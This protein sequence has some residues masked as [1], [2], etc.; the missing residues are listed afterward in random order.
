MLGYTVYA[1]AVVPLVEPSVKLSSS[2]SDFVVDSRDDVYSGLFPP[3]S[4]EQEHPKILETEHGTLLFD[5]YRPGE[6]RRQLHLNRCSFVRFLTSG[7]TSDPAI[8]REER[9]IILR[10]P[11]GATLVFDKPMDLAR[12]EF[13]NLVGGQLEGEIEIY[14]PPSK[15]GADDA[16][17]I[18]T[19]DIQIDADEIWTEADVEFRYGPNRG[20]GR[21]LH[22]RWEGAP[23][24]SSASGSRGIHSME[25]VHL[26][27]LTLEIPDDAEG[28]VA[29]QRNKADSDGASPTVPIA[30]AR[31]DRT[32]VDVSCQ[33]P[34]RWDMRSNALTLH[35][36]VRILRHATQGAS[37]QLNCELL[38][39]HFTGGVED[40]PQVTASASKTRETNMRLKKILA[41][42]FPVI[43]RL[44]SRDLTVRAERMEYDFLERRFFLEDTN[45]FQVEDARY[46][47][48]ARRMEYWLGDQGRLGS[49]SAK[50]PGHL[51]G[52]GDE[53]TPPFEV[54][55][56]DEIVLRP[57]EEQPV[58]SLLGSAWLQWD[59]TSQFASD[60]LHVF[61]NESL[62]RRTKKWVVQ[63]DRMKALGH[64]QVDSPQ[65]V[66]NLNEANI[67]FRHVP[68]ATGEGETRA[69]ESSPHRP[70]AGN[71]R[72][73]RSASRPKDV[74]QYELTA[75]LLRAQVVLEDSL[76]VDRL[77]LTGG[78]TFRERSAPG[79]AAM[80]M[81]G[82]TF[83]L[84]GGTT[85]A[86]QAV[87]VGRP[88]S[89][90]ARGM[91]L[92]GPEIIV[93]QGSNTMEIDGSGMMTISPS[94]RDVN[95][96][97]MAPTHIEW[98]DGMT[99]DGSLA[100][101]VGNVTVRGD[102]PAEDGSWTRL[103]VLAESL[104]ATLTRRVDFSRPRVDGKT[105]L[106]RLACRQEVFL[107]TQWFDRGGERRAWQQMQSQNLMVDQVS[108][109]LRGDGPGWLTSVH[110][111][112]SW[113][114]G[115]DRLPP[116]GHWQSPLEYLR[117]DFARE[118]RGQLNHG[119]I[120][121]LGKVRTIYGP[122]DGWNERI[123]LA[124][125]TQLPPR[126]VLLNCDR[127]AVADMSPRVGALQSIELE[128]TGNAIV[129]GETFSA[130]GQRI[131]YN[132]AK[133]Q[134][135]LEGDGRTDAV[136]KYAPQPGAAPAELTGRKIL[137]WPDTRQFELNDV[138]S[139]DIRD[140]PSLR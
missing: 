86:A 134:L 100:R 75:D 5:D 32:P 106:G 6:D 67:W 98:R 84:D 47:V 81:T 52:L 118:L 25:L 38:E 123:E 119:Q 117:V 97:P 62:D 82:D 65:L 17:R 4:W 73:Q 64:V 24:T 126:V 79:S 80:V 107:E 7:S 78:V 136:L 95:K 35:D 104:E 60:E 19:R 124:R 55:W 54:T 48:E 130:A 101:F 57:Y 72:S 27:E 121:F 20:R 22:I 111:R 53:S 13:G 109:S 63:P 133:D 31:R 49:L 125:T 16:I 99:F 56:S 92:K 131:S 96:P 105:E 116:A 132:R 85:D 44:P 102:R 8:Q 71:E 83:Q 94:A 42:G 139:L 37:D 66:A 51:W 128:A 50:G 89:V 113:S 29:G 70:V 140:L 46:R 10:A 12:G 59:G 91:T 58:L 114:P 103:L 115:R 69:G 23:G 112:G 3:G 90:T 110:R 11:H 26:D 74:V 1:L 36:H 39:L 68:K 138:R 33:G 28:K 108:G 15:P 76:Q 2:P 30:A 122:V 135:V 18:T 14:G 120:E 87:L 93:H 88:A 41:I 21:D 129:R 40:D 61:L 43:A 34:L 127:L 45:E 137:Y 77:S 9:P